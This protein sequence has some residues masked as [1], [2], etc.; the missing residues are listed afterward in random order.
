M[1]YVLSKVTATTQP[2]GAAN[3]C[4]YLP[5]ENVRWIEVTRMPRARARDALH[6]GEGATGGRRLEWQRKREGL[7]LAVPLGRVGVRLTDDPRLHLCAYTCQC[8]YASVSVLMHS[9]ACAHPRVNS[10]AIV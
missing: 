2:R 1:Q 9:C 3:L 4:T 6:A 10:Y 5:R 7:L 8:L